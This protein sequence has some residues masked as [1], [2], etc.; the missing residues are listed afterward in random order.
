MKLENLTASDILIQD[1]KGV[2][3][4]LPASESP[5]GVTFKWSSPRVVNVEGW[6]LVSLHTGIPQP[7]GIPKHVD[8]KKIYLVSRPLENLVRFR[9]DIFAPGPKLSG[10]GPGLYRGLMTTRYS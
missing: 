8:P 1:H 2:V 4:E 10:E 6:G 5:A 9:Q 7:R 3:H